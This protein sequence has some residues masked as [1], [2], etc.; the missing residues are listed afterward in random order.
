VGLSCSY[1]AEPEER[2]VECMKIRI[3]IFKKGTKYQDFLTGYV[4]EEMTKNE[5]SGKIL[6]A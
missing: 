4:L 3:P 6:I 1:V 2:L 5:T